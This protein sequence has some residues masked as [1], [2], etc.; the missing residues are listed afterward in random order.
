MTQ[1]D[2]Q[3]FCEGVQADLASLTSEPENT[4]VSNET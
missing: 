1:P 4:F 3:L 2:A